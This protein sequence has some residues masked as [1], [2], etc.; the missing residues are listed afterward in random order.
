MNWRWWTGLWF[1]E[2]MCL[3]RS[4]IYHY[5]PSLGNWCNGVGTS[6]RVVGRFHEISNPKSIR[7]C[8]YPISR[9]VEIPSQIVKIR[10][11]HSSVILSRIS[12]APLLAS[13]NFAVRKACK[14]LAFSLPLFIFFSQF[15]LPPSFKFQ[16]LY[17]WHKIL[18]FYSLKDCVFKASHYDIGSYGFCDSQ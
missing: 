11:G 14:H 12:Y 5:L 2:D 17:F 15:T 9:A 4:S 10:C 3:V 13:C 16:L 7:F 8:V 1:R 18:L 6:E